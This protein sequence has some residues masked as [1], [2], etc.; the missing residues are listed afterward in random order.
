MGQ[1]D[2]LSEDDRYDSEDYYSWCRR[3]AAKVLDEIDAD[4][5]ADAGDDIAE[6]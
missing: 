3:N 2:Q 4:D 5:E 6:D 1:A